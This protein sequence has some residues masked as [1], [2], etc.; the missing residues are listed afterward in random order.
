[1]KFNI[2]K[3]IQLSPNLKLL[4]SLCFGSFLLNVSVLTPLLIM[5]WNHSYYCLTRDFTVQ[6]DVT[7]CNAH[8]LPVRLLHEC[9]Q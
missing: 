3:P 5:L 4:S 6:P 2:T 9:C 8:I 7:F 1:M